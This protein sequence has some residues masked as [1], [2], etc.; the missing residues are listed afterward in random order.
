MPKKL[1]PVFALKATL[2]LFAMMAGATSVRAQADTLGYYEDLDSLSIF[3][4]I[5]SVLS[6][7]T[8]YS[9]LHLRLSYT[10]RVTSAGRDLNIKQYGFTPGIT[11][12]HHSGIYAD[13]S[14]YWNSQLKPQYSLT[15][16]TLGYLGIPAKWLSYNLAAERSF[17]NTAG[18]DSV[19]TAPPNGLNTAVF[20]DAKWVYTSVDYTYL[21]GN[22]SAHRLQFSLSGNF[23]FKEV[24][25]IDK[26]TLFPTASALFGNEELISYRYNV[27]LNDPRVRRILRR[28]PR[29]RNQALIAESENVFGLMN[30]SLSAPASFRYKNFSLLLSYTCNIPIELPGEYL[31]DP[32]PNSYFSGS[33]SY[34]IPII[35]SPGF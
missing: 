25:F 12:Y 14:G 1:L 33:L 4:L 8:K 24:F 31:A 15:A 5:D 7:D 30:I 9:S 35:R 21:F 6:L 34:M 2:A 3:R 18:S 29:L 27:D 20:M 11:Y 16:A 32:S 10:S 26:I 17:Y 22:G 28:N 23:E 13:L 19:I